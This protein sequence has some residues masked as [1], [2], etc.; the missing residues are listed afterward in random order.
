[1]VAIQ[2]LILEN[3]RN[4]TQLKQRVLLVKRVS[5]YLPAE[6]FCR[7]FYDCMMDMRQRRFPRCERHLND[8]DLHD[9]WLDGV[10]ASRNIDM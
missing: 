8:G 3:D 6:L 1:M 4:G 7:L 5:A 2:H 9:Q 10:C